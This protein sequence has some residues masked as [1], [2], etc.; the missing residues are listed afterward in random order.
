MVVMTSSVQRTPAPTTISN[1][2]LQMATGPERVRPISVTM[3]ARA[4]QQTRGAFICDNVVF[5]HQPDLETS[6]RS[7]FLASN[8]FLFMPEVLSAPIHDEEALKKVSKADLKGN[9]DYERYAREKIFRA[10]IKRVSE[11][12]YFPNYNEQVFSLLE[13]AHFLE[14][15]TLLVERYHGHSCVAR[16]T[17]PAKV[18]GDIHGQFS[19]LRDIF[20]CFGW[21]SRYRGDIEGMSYIFNGDFVDRGKQ[22][23][24]VVAFLFCCKLVYPNNIVLVRGNHELRHV[25]KSHGFL[26]ELPH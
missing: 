13:P 10:L 3:L 4:P 9:V 6:A 21:P 25:N 12:Q 7:S 2:L 16:V 23:L 20:S 8:K 26:E 18:F 11:T 19:D 17:A 22:S 5:A 24:E 14:L 15:C 1:V